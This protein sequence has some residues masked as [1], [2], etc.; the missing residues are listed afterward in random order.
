MSRAVTSAGALRLQPAVGGIARSRGA[1][2]YP[3]DMTDAE[4]EFCEPL[5]AERRGAGRAADRPGTLRVVVD[6]IG[7][8]VRY[9]VEWRALP[10]DFPPAR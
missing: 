2:R 3:S 1:R 10:A 9:G 7:Y 8:L 6:A 5:L 4:W